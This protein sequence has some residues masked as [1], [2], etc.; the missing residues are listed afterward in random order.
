VS[1]QSLPQIRLQQSGNNVLV[2]KIHSSIVNAIPLWKSQM[3][4]ALGLAQTSEAMK[5]EKAVSDTTNK[6]L[7]QNS[8]LLKTTTIE[9]A[10]ESERGI[11]D[12]E[13]VTKANE[14]I[15]STIKQVVSIQQESRLKRQEAETELKRLESEL[16]QNIIQALESK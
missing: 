13:T 1:L 14:D 16:K 10:K 3:V 7:R 6:L 11:V 2:D 9:A 12:I 8:E 4:I 5:A 15:I